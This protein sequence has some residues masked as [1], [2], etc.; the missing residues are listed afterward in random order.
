MV[1]HGDHDPTVHHLNADHLIETALGANG[2]RHTQHRTQT[3][4]SRVPG[5]RRYTST[6]Y[7]DAAAVPIVERLTIHQGGHAWSGGPPG[8]YTDPLGPD[9]SAELVRFFHQHQHGHHVRRTA[10]GCGSTAAARPPRSPNT[11]TSPRRSS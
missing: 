11:S 4:E 9:A 6:T 2:D 5:G 1:I 7:T 10:I 3:T 8:P